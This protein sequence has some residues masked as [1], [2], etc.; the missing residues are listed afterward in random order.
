M[1][2][3]IEKRMVAIVCVMFMGLNTSAQSTTQE[4]TTKLRLFKPQVGF[5]SQGSATRSGADLSGGTSR[6]TAF[7]GGPSTEPAA[8]RARENK[9]VPNSPTLTL[10][11][12]EPVRPTGNIQ[13]V[14]GTQEADAPESPLAA[15]M[16]RESELANQ[17]Q[18]AQ[19]PFAKPPPDPFAKQR[20]DERARAMALPP[21]GS[22]AT[23]AADGTLGRQRGQGNQGF[24][25]PPNDISLPQQDL[26]RGDTA[27]LAGLFESAGSAAAGNA[28]GS[29]AS[30]GAAGTGDDLLYGTTRNASSTANGSMG[31]GTT[32]PPSV[33]QSLPA[34]W[35]PQHLEELVSMFGIPRNEPKLMDPNYLNYLHN[36][37]MKRR[38]MEARDAA[39][40]A[41]VASGSFGL[42]STTLGNQA[43]AGAGTF[44]TS[45]TGLASNGSLAGYDAGR[46]PRNGVNALYS[47]SNGGLTGG[48]TRDPMAL[49][50]ERSSAAL[51]NAGQK[52]TIEETLER[53]V[54]ERLLREREKDARAKLLANQFNSNPY[55]NAYYPQNGGMYSGA[56]Y[57]NG[58]PPNP[59]ING[60]NYSPPGFT[61]QGN[62]FQGQPNLAPPQQGRPSPQTPGNGQNAQAEDAPPTSPSDGS[63]APDHAAIGAAPDVRSFSPL[64]NVALLC[65]IGFQR[66][67]LKP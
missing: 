36:E 37:F 30:Q 57:P 16:R 52:E 54:Q 11:S 18:A 35:T 8:P 32:F 29:A 60:A 65:S 31:A 45:N 19:Q 49:A 46:Q 67:R 14:S 55:P 21:G 48:Q 1:G 15:R 59:Q 53:M 22:P 42:P 20:A 24:I 44:N 34:N 26:G 9:W 5:G 33:I 6:A 28:F 13:T 41:R 23:P 56:P 64:V 17:R 25:K 63:D 47:G 27:S 39:Q 3:T 50:G 51:Q 38:E 10:P 61:S 66:N 12:T 40:N 43:A 58:M 7:P 2:G 4:P 62:I